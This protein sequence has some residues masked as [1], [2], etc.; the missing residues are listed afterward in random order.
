MNG[1]HV[2]LFGNAVAD[3][4]QKYT[5]ADGRPYAELRVA[6]NSYF[7]EDREKETQYFSIRLYGN[8]M[9]QALSRAK[10]GQPVW[11][12][13]RLA[14]RLYQRR[15]GTAGMGM[16]VYAREF[17]VLHRSPDPWTEDQEASEESEGPEA[18]AQSEAE[19]GADGGGEN[20]TEA[21]KEPK[22]GPRP[23]PQP[24]GTA[25]PATRRGPTGA[26]EEQDLPFDSPV[27]GD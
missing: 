25:E 26:E 14:T 22:A 7:G 8:H 2:T 21:G 3:A 12:Q 9:D 16:D 19:A 10:Q 11:V 15:D 24:R 17:R 13:G 20:E 27:T 6:C 4:E 1:P 23:R 18:D 5:W